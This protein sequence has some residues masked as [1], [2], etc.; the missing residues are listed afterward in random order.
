M[1]RSALA[2]VEE[3]DD[4]SSAADDDEVAGGVGGLPLALLDWRKSPSI[5][6]TSS[7]DRVFSGSW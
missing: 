7:D 1:R 2:L 3:D 5:S 6:S 4:G